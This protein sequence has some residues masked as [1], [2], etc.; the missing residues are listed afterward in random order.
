MKAFFLSSLLL[1]LTSTVCFGQL[2]Y[3]EN[4]YPV[5]VEEDIVYGTA[6]GYDGIVDTLRMDIYRPV[7]DG[8]CQRP[9]L[10]LVHGGAWMAGSKDEGYMPLIAQDMAEKGWV[11]AAINYR[12]GMHK[13]SNYTQYWACTPDLAQPCSYMTDSSEVIRAIYRAQQD[14]KGAIRFMKDRAFTDSTDINNVFLCGESA[15]GFNV[16]AATFLNDESEKFPAASAISNAPNPDSDLTSC[17]EPGYSLARP[18]LGSVHGSLNVGSHNANVEGVANIYGGL[19]N[20]DLFANES[21]WPALY[22]FHQGSD[23]IVH[24]NYGRILGRLDGECLSIAN[25][26]QQY[27]VPPHAY[28]SKGI[29]AY[30]NSLPS[31]PLLTAEIIENYEYNNDC[32]DNG[33]SIDNWQQR[34]QNFCD[35]FAQR[36][37]Q[38][39]NPGPSCEMGTT[40]HELSVSV[41]PNPSS[42]FITINTPLAD[43]CT[44]RI[45][46]AQGRVVY[47]QAIKK[48]LHLFLKNGV[49][50]ISVTDGIQHFY[51]RVVIAQ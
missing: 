7:G 45:S 23:V 20:F 49:Y 14:V 37:L 13:Q 32:F 43:N 44:I 12:L 33:H 25:I 15:G 42:G 35:L 16:L 46:D 34:T 3:T 22:F 26:C 10:V 19:L 51:K 48:T 4:Q 5:T 8:N 18:D 29:A 1:I 47:D 24:Y 50:T 36:I 17:L 28:G 30:L 6:I 21:D 9:C 41:F 31:P 38:N 39:G 11:V 2:S 27:S 40:N